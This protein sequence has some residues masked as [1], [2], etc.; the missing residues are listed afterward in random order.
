MEG[1]IRSAMSFKVLGT[2]G[3][4]MVTLKQLDEQGV[5][6]LSKLLN[7]S[8]ATLIVPEVWKLGRVIQLLKPGKDASKI[9]SNRLMY[10]SSK[11]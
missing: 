1:V 2:D 11:A 10:Y 3:I 5:E 7:L 9:D 6:Y 8:L 4:P